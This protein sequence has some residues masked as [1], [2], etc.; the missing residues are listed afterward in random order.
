MIKVEVQSSLFAV[1]LRKRSEET[2]LCPGK[3]KVT[4]MFSAE[5]VLGKSQEFWD[6]SFKAEYVRK[7]ELCLCFC[8]CFSSCPA[9]TCDGCTFHF[10]WESSSACPHCA[11][12][13]Y[14]Q[15]DGA[16][17]GGVQVRTLLIQ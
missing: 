10:L 11:E 17:K 4:V 3:Q 9:G 7:C 5:R 14:H 1:T 13:D 6:E 2:F 12:E 15:I 8:L 16:C